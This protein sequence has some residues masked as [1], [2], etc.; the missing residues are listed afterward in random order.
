MSRLLGASLP[1]DL[2]D[3][4]RASDLAPLADKVI[5]LFT[6]DAAGWA[7]PALLSYFEVT[8]A[9]REHLRIATY[10][11]STTSGNIR[12]SGRVTLVFID[13]RMAYYVKGTAVEIAASMQAAGWNAA[14]DCRI[15]QVLADEVD[16]AYEPG[17][18][19]AGG[20]TYYSPQRPEQLERARAV[21]AELVALPA[22]ARR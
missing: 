19:V 16:E 15:E 13:T 18:Y 11:D 10:A 5:Q 22:P 4:L 2:F 7:H 12:R 21:L 3:R 17:A 9:D 6:V 20:V 14:F 1:P 8:A